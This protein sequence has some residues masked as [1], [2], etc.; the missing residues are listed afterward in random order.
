MAIT[1]IAAI[2]MTHLAETPAAQAANGVL[3]SD[4]TAA[5]CVDYLLSLFREELQQPAPKVARLSIALG[6]LELP[7]TLKQEANQYWPADLQQQTETCLEAF[8][9]FV[10]QMHDRMQAA[11]TLDAR[12]SGHSSWCCITP[13][14]DSLNSMP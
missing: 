5:A 6:A 12:V 9:V 14:R 4:P 1:S 3:A 7:L 13:N 8:E 10:G 11:G 2:T